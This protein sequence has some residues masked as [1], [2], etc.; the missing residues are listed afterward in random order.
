MTGPVGATV[1]GR[2]S[3]SFFA[4]ALLSS[5]QSSWLSPG[6]ADVCA[7]RAA[8]APSAARAAMIDFTRT[9]SLEFEMHAERAFVE[10]RREGR[11]GGR[12]EH[13]ALRRPVHEREP[14]RPL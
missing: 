10:V 6:G 3:G 12:R 1:G 2:A 5:S 11:Q 14:A 13:G 9:S 8:A 7:A 4:T